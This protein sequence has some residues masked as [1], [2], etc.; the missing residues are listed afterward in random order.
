MLRMFESSAAMLFLWTGCI[1]MGAIYLFGV[2]DGLGSPAFIVGQIVLGVVGMLREAY[3]IRH[4]VR[5]N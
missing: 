3:I 4:Y 1:V 5:K 2:W